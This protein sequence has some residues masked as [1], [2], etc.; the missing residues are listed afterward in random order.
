MATMRKKIER[1][2][3]NRARSNNKKSIKFA[4]KLATKLKTKKFS[5]HVPNLPSPKTSHWTVSRIVT[6]T[7]ALAVFFAALSFFMELAPKS[8]T[9]FSQQKLTQTATLNLLDGDGR[10]TLLATG[11][12]LLARYVEQKMRQLKDYTYPFHHVADF[13]RSADI[14]FGNLETPLLSGRN[15]PTNH[16]TFRGDPEA[17]AGLKFA[18]YDVVSI[19]NNHTMNYRIPGLTSTIKALNQNEILYV[20]GGKNINIAHTPALIER[21]GVKIA[22][23]A[24]NDSTIPP[25]RHGEATEKMPGIASM[26]IEAVKNDVKNAFSIY[27]ADIA[28]VSM[29]AGKEFTSEPTQFQKDFAHA[30]IDAGASVVIGHHPHW[31]QPVEYYGN[32]VIFYSLGNFVFDQMYSKETTTGFIAQIELELG[33]KPEVELIPVVIEGVQPK[34]ASLE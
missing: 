16:M 3:I 31:I 4:A 27:G 19:A 28:V 6:I 26:D 32:G 17:A 18:G 5:K 14:T 9:Q 22:F 29:H 25:R 15:T 21:D 23:Y 2:K 12:I 7:L 30:A 11:D 1:K 24:Y 34:I 20:G 8:P 13:L 33:E 10:V